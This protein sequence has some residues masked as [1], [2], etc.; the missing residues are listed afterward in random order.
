M[1]CQRSG[2]VGVDPPT[3]GYAHIHMYTGL[4]E[5]VNHDLECRQ[6]SSSTFIGV[7]LTNGGGSG[8]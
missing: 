7:F 6:G 3:N 8:K 1:R 5:Y 2:A 4:P